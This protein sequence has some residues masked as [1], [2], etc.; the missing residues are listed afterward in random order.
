MIGIRPYEN[1]CMQPHDFGCLTT[2]VIIDGWSN[3]MASCAQAE[4]RYASLHALQVR[5]LSAQPSY[6]L[7]LALGR[8]W[9]HKIEEYQKHSMNFPRLVEH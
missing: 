9:L 3:N 8:L 1:R 7:A 5:M 6:L 2:I 4:C